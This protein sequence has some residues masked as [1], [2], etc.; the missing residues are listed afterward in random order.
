MCCSLG[1]SCRTGRF[2]GLQNWEAWGTHSVHASAIPM[3]WSGLAASSSP[4]VLGERGF[5]C[6]SRAGLLLG[7]G[8]CH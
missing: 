7:V 4:G 1:S 2:V 8:I 3:E 6:G 5:L